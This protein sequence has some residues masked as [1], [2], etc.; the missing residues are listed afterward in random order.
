MLVDEYT[1]AGEVVVATRFVCLACGTSAL[2][3]SSVG[4]GFLLGSGVFSVVAAG[5]SFVS[6]EAHAWVVGIF[7]LGLGAFFGFLSWLRLRDARRNPRW[8]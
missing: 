2:I 5:Y 7:S 4:Q 8:G 6:K 1:R 3:L